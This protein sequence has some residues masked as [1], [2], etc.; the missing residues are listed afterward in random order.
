M[1]AASVVP[2]GAVRVLVSVHVP[3]LV[4]VA[5]TVAVEPSPSAMNA[6]TVALLSGV[7]SVELTVAN[8]TFTAV[9]A[10]AVEP[11]VNLCAE[12]TDKMSTA[13]PA[14]CPWLLTKV[15]PDAAPAPSVAAQT[16]TSGRTRVCVRAGNPGVGRVACSGS[17]ARSGAA[18]GS[19]D[20][21]GS[22]GP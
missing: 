1:L 8:L 4:R 9:R 18:E 11:V 5:T 16:S 7:S 20:R 17:R 19:A 14:V 12:S 3:G 13:V 6:V 10:A 2:D 22:S 21:C 15:S